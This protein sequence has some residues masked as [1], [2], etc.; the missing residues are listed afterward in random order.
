MLSLQHFVNYIYEDAQTST[1]NEE[2]RQQ[3]EKWLKD[4]KYPDYV[5]T[6]DKMLKDPKARVLLQDGF[7]GDLGDIKFVFQPRLIKAST[8][9]PTQSEIDVDKSLTHALTTV[10]NIKNDFKEDIVVADT[11]IVTFRGNYVIDGHHRWSEIVMVNPAGRMLCL[12]Y[13]ADISPVQM[14]KAVQGAIAAVLSKKDGATM[15]RGNTKSQNIY[16]S[17]LTVDKIKKYVEDTITD[18]VV[19]ELCL[20]YSMC[21]DKDDV[22]KVLVDN[23]IQFKV[24][25]PPITNAQRRDDMPQ[26]F[27]AGSKPGDSMTADPNDEGSALNKLKSGK[28]TKSVL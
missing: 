16:D 24:N 18:D 28:F 12:D 15:P 4:K 23:I 27:S 9:V 1:S 26:P 17:S 14:L 5:N 6:L 25:N 10:E 3:L 8:L 20:H 7:G 21:S 2:R 19:K 22:V 11:P 13:D